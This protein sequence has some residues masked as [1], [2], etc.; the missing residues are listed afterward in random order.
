ML[1]S[2]SLTFPPQS[3]ML[4]SVLERQKCR[5]PCLFVFVCFVLVL[6]LFA[7][8]GI[9]YVSMF[10]AK[11]NGVCLGRFSSGF[12]MYNY[13]ALIEGLKQGWL[14]SVLENTD[15]AVFCPETDSWAGFSTHSWTFP[16][17]MKLFWVVFI[18]CL[19]GLF[20]LSRFFHFCPPWLIK[21]CKRPM[22]P[23]LIN[24][25]QQA[26]QCWN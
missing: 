25:Y 20:S 26:S 11:A 1:S 10:V 16:Y 6:F 19:F 23:I 21:K 7:N 18:S 24:K 14:L 22:S 17:K 15:A 8:P 3:H 4:L 5:C 2:Q 12:L 13:A 9:L